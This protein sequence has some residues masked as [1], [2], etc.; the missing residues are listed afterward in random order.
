MVKGERFDALRL[1]GGRYGRS[2]L[3]PLQASVTPPPRRHRPPAERPDLVTR[4]IAN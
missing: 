3:D 1:A 2:E 4:C